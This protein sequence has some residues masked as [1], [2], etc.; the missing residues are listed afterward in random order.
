M[1]VEMS[2]LRKEVI[3][4]IPA[5]SGSQSIIHKNIQ[6]LSGKPLMFYSIDVAKKTQSIEKVFISTDDRFYA[7]IARHYGGEVPFL[8]PQEISRS[9]SL[10]KEV[11]SHFLNKLIEN[12][13]ENFD[14][15]IVFLRPTHP[16]RDPLFL[17]QAI[18]KFCSSSACMIRSISRAEQTP[19]KMWK[20]EE[21]Q[22]LQR[23]V[24]RMEDSMHDYPRQN[25]PV[26]YWQDGY[27]DCLRK[28]SLSDD[29]CQ[30]HEIRIGGIVSPKNEIDVDYPDEFQEQQKLMNEKTEKEAIPNSN[31]I[32]RSLD[33]NRFSS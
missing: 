32:I 30:V 22:E 23:V 11:I 26:V 13:G 15:I 20:Y 33:E 17:E 29:K 10:D 6:S 9:E 14:P 24:G 25:L 5:R 1:V 16:M 18:Q 21:G 12:Q 19:Y 2:N 28:C 4:L 3:A 27:V 7:D 8:R 31:R